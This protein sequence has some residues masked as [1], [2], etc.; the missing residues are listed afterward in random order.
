VKNPNLLISKLLG[1]E[2]KKKSAKQV[3]VECGYT[4]ADKSPQEVMTDILKVFPLVIEADIG[5]MPDTEKMLAN[6][7]IQAI[8]G[9][10][11]TSLVET[12]LQE[13]SDNG[14]YMGNTLP[15]RTELGNL[16]HIAE[17]Q[18]LMVCERARMSGFMGYAGGDV[19]LRQKKDGS[20]DAF[21]IDFNPR[22]NGSTAFKSH[23][24]RLKQNTGAPVHGLNTNI[25]LPSPVTEFGEVTRLIGKH[26]FLN[27]REDSN[28]QGLVPASMRGFPGHANP[29]VKMSILAPT[30]E[31]LFALLGSLTE[32][33][34]KYGS[35]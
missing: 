34:I 13:T 23:V 17:E 4:V 2:D 7:N 15:L 12:S 29:I 30:R 26:N 14:N 20:H 5:T 10:S 19:M 1:L 8:V 18:F 32:K 3:A 6:F 27:F 11:G 22:L 33:G 9:T 25:K 16:A 35:F 31:Q 28:N 21:A 24:H